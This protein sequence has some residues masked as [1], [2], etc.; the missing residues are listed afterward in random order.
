[1]L[2][3]VDGSAVDVPI[4]ATLKVETLTQALNVAAPKNTFNLPITVSVTKGPGLTGKLYGLTGE[5]KATSAT[6]F[7]MAAAAVQLAVSRT[8]E[9]DATVVTAD[10]PA[11]A[12]KNNTWQLPA[13]PNALTCTFIF[14][15]TDAIPGLIVPVVL[16]PSSSSSSKGGSGSKHL[17]GPAM[18]FSFAPGG[19]SQVQTQQLGK[20]A[21]VS[22]VF[23]LEDEQPADLLIPLVRERDSDNGAALSGQNSMQGGLL[24]ASSLAMPGGIGTHQPSAFNS[25]VCHSHSGSQADSQWR[26]MLLWCCSWH[27]HHSP[28]VLLTS[29]WTTPDCQQLSAQ[30]TH[31]SQ[32]RHPRAAAMPFR[33]QCSSQ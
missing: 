12:W 3:A 15:T 4:P 32:T 5:I 18:P 17:A 6:K 31:A 11:S 33:C 13:A 10:C 26:C 8:G 20:C 29:R 30:N 1:M 27:S 22:E 19:G 9:D 16:L 7:P 23:G 2:H 24:R 25:T 28:S 21:A 14:N